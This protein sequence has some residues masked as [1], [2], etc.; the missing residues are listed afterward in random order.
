MRNIFSIKPFLKK[1]YSY[2][3]NPYRLFFDKVSLPKLNENQTLKCESFI[4]E[5]K[6]LKAWIMINHQEM[7]A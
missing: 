1:N 2:R 5:C 3:N 7:M 6:C 4:T